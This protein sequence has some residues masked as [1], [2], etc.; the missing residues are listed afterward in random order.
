M[1]KLEKDCMATVLD[2][3]DPE[4]LSGD[5]SQVEPEQLEINH[6]NNTEGLTI[7]NGAL[8]NFGLENNKLGQ[9]NLLSS[10]GLPDLSLTD[11]RI[12][13]CIL[14]SNKL[15]MLGEVKLSHPKLE[16]GC[17]VEEL[18]WVESL[19]LNNKAADIDAK[20][21]DSGLIK[22]KPTDAYHSNKTVSPPPEPLVNTKTSPR[23][24][25]CLKSKEEFGFL[26]LPNFLTL[27]VSLLFLAYG[28]SAPVVY[29]VPYALSVGVGHQQAAFLMSIYGV[30]SI[31]GNI[32]FGWITDRK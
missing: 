21:E 2:P 23:G 5:C 13:E 7:A 31:V 12:A 24:C 16:N 9:G 25:F 32:T 20:K 22:A 10:L 30:S 3:K 8:K 19:N 15:T 14:F 11:Q 6:L 17:T 1:A 28:C 18:K 27:S 4:E 29:L 26:M